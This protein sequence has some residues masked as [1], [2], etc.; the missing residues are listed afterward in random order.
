MTNRLINTVSKNLS[1]P[2]SFVFIDDYFINTVEG[3]AL[4]LENVLQR[5]EATN[6]KLHPGKCV[7]AQPKVKY[8]G[9][10]LSEKVVSPFPDKVKTVKQYP[11]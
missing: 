2:E 3:H 6:L 10:V 7:L 1:G 11:H 4:R 8:L 5:F 9:F